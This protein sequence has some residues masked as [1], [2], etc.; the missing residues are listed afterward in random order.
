MKIL[1]LLRQQELYR[2]AREGRGQ[3]MILWAVLIT[4]WSTFV[5]AEP[6]ADAVCDEAL[7]RT[8]GEGR[9]RFLWDSLVSFWMVMEVFVLQVRLSSRGCPGTRS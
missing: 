1:S 5:S 2:S 6:Q 3:P 4:L 7:D 8:P 9:Q